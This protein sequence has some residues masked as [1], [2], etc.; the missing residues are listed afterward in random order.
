MDEADSS[1]TIPDDASGMAEFQKLIAKASSNLEKRS[2][3]P[4]I[5]ADKKASK[6]KDFINQVKSLPT[7][8]QGSSF[9][10]FKL[11]K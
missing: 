9:N 10:S 6:N 4:K 1:N 2:P 8:I 3:K 7:E 11:K 5:S